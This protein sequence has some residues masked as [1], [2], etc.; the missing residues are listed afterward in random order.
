MKN[1]K[2]SSRPGAKVGR[3][4]PPGSARAQPWTTKEKT[5][6]DLLLNSLNLNVFFKLQLVLYIPVYFYLQVYYPRP[7]KNYLMEFI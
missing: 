4:G 3:Q 2:F 6:F 7:H 1:L 5:T